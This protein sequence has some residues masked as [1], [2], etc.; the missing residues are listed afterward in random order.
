MTEE[1]CMWKIR[2]KTE[3]YEVEVVGSDIKAVTG[4]FEY[5]AKRYSK[6][7]VN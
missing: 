6:L 1:S 2:V 3:D 7:A 5:V 4:L